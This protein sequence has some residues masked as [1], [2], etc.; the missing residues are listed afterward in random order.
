MFRRILIAVDGSETSNHALDTGLQLARQGQASVRVVH[1]LDELASVSGYPYS[2]QLRDVVR[3]EGQK[4]LDDA[5]AIARKADV[6]ADAELVNQPDGRLGEMVA[7]AA[8]AWNADLVV[9]GTHGRRGIGRVLLGSGAEEVVRM[10]PVP[11]L[12]VRSSA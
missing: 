4:I 7:N 2:A 10:A 5:L 8:R 6:P 11:V 3:Q 9:V 12:T 1:A